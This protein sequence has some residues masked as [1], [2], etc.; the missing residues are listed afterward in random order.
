MAAGDLLRE[1]RARALG[2]L[3][4]CSDAHGFAASAADRGGQ[5]RIQ[6][7][8]GIL[9]G[10]AALAWDEGE[11]TRAFRRTLLTLA[12]HQGPDGEIPESIDPTTAR[13]S[14]GRGG[15]RRPGRVVP[16]RKARSPVARQYWRPPAARA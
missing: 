9:A 6:A 3:A 1:G 7:R 11:L 5:R 13:V 12:P 16:D 2:L 8:D 14:Y 10:L 15:A 4:R